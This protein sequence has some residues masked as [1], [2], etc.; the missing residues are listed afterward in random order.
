MSTGASHSAAFTVKRKAKQEHTTHSKLFTEGSVTNEF[1]RNAA[2]MQ[3]VMLA[4]I[5][6]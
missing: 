3:W 1:G 5:T 6:G 4:I 2:K